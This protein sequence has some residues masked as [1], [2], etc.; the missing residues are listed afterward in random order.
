MRCVKSIFLFLIITANFIIV[1]AQEKLAWSEINTGLNEEL[2][3]VSGDSKEN[4]WVQTQSGKLLKIKNRK[5]TIYSPPFP[6]KIIRAQYF[7]VSDDDFICSV[8]TS[9]WEGEIYRIQNN[10]W[11]KYK[12]HNKYPI[13]SIHKTDDNDFYIVGDFGTLLKFKN[14]KWEVIPTPFDSHIVS[15][16]SEGNNLYCATRG[17]GVILF[18]GSNFRN[19]S[20]GIHKD[21]INSLKMINHVLYGFSTNKRLYCYKSNMEEILDDN[22]ILSLFIEKNKNSNFGFS[23]KS[24]YSKNRIIPLSFPQSYNVESIDTLVDGSFLLLSNNGKI[25]TSEDSPKISFINLAP[26]YRIDDLPN[27]INSGRAFFDA[28]NDG[29]SDLIVFNHKRGNYISLFRGV[30]NSAFANITSISGLPFNENP[31]LFYT[32]MDFDKDNLNDIVLQFQENSLQKIEF[33]KNIGNFQFKNFSEISLPDDFQSLGIRNLSSFDY[34]RDG[35]EDLIVTSYYGVKDNPGYLLIYKNNYWGNFDEIDTTFKAF[36]THWNENFIFADLNGDDKLDIF[37]STSWANDKLFFG[38]NGSYYRK[39]DSNFNKNEKTETIDAVLSDFDNDG[40]LDI[41]TTGKYDFIR[42]FSNDGKGVFSEI[43]SNLFNEKDKFKSNLKISYNLNLADFNND[44]FIDILVTLNYPDSNYTTI[45]LNK[46]GHYFSEFS[47][48]FG[49]KHNQISGSTISDF[50]NDGDLDIYVTTK[51]HN[52]FLV[53]TLNDNNSVK[54]KLK[55]V[56]SSRN[57]LGT[58]IW[59]YKNNHLNDAKSLIGYKQFGTEKISRNRS[60]DLVIHFGLDSLKSCDIK[61]R[62]LSGKE[63]VKQ[64][65][66]VGSFLTIEEYSALYAFFYNIPGNTYRFLRNGENQ[67]YL[68]VII[69]SHFLLLFGL[70]YGFNKL[71]W[72]PKLTLFFAMLNIPLFWMSLYFA[73]FSLITFTKFLVPLLLTFLVTTIPLVLFTWINRS[74]KKDVS[75]YNEKLLKLVMSFS[76]GEWALRNLNSILLLCENAPNDWRN[77]LDF[78][79]KLETRFKTFTE[80]T[81]ISI[82]EIIDLKKLSENQT[83]ELNILENSLSEVLKEVDNFSNIHSLMQIVEYFTIIRESLKNIRISTYLLFSSNPTDVINNVIESFRVILDENKIYVSKAREYA[84]DIPVLI[85]SYELGDIID[86]LIQNSL[87]FMKDSKEKNIFI[88]LYKESPKIILRFSNNGNVIPND[89]WDIIFEQGYTES[90]SSG[91]GL[92]NAREILK[93]YGGRIYVEDSTIEKTTFKIELNE[94][95]SN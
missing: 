67:I 69:I 29:V 94:G 28:N 21:Y 23:E 82:K 70:W 34:D 47:I 48:D 68:L 87:R 10:K 86:N 77:N 93:K 55:G 5:T 56:S 12:F 13:R 85:K 1:L 75:S 64:S 63:I 16:V 14:N 73:S 36:T 26:T 50:D 15:S 78:I 42:V 43:T 53:N 57:A 40:D 25:Y 81:S 35:D 51:N 37:N 4:F 11:K 84:T 38:E 52:L 18:D 49:L 59:V 33:Y 74:R 19:L 88:E 61:V 92:F 3:F 17:D 91:Q 66:V 90:K 22:E 71:N 45:F 24:I 60:N 8:T 41:F 9:D 65:V 83:E 39:T 76:H 46:N 58:K 32:I 72:S 6:N 54:I 44:S 27:S 7:R 2:V 89:K 95:V 31:I 62:F 80:M 20:S 79:Q 30:P